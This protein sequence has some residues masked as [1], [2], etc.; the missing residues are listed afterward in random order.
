MCHIDD[1]KGHLHG[2]EQIETFAQPLLTRSYELFDP[3]MGLLT[4]SQK[5]GP[6][7]SN[8]LGF[9][10]RRGPFISPGWVPQKAHNGH[11]KWLCKGLRYIGISVG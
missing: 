8:S 6:G 10:H 9:A 11:S 2:K 5:L 7:A 1:K 3:S 4:K